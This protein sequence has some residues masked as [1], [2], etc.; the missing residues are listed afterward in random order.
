MKLRDY[1]VR[2]L[3]ELWMWFEKHDGGNPIVEACVGAGKSLMIAALAQRA[4]T[5]FPGTRILVLVH[6][7]ELLEQNIEKLLAIWP[8]A[9]VG[10][11][12]AAAGKK[13]LGYQRTYATIGS[14]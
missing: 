1:Q 13:Q 12:S 9:N 2:A 6:Q 10:L 11:Y 8:T 5:E 3:D 4:D 7:K 14:I